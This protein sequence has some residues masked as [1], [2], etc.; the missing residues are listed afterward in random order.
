MGGHGETVD[1][2]LALLFLKRAFIAT[3]Y[4]ESGDA[5]KK[6]AKEDKDKEKK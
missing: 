3:P 1:T 4:I 5:R 2:C 6:P